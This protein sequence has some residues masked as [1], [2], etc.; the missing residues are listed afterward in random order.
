L[1]VAVDLNEFIEGFD[2]HHAKQKPL[3]F[4]FHT[5]Y[6]CSTLLARCLQEINNTLVLKEPAPL[7]S[8]SQMWFGELPESD[9]GKLKTVVGAL[10]ARRFASEHVIVKTTSHCSNIMRELLELHDDNRAVFLYASLEETLASFL[11]DPARRREARRY[12][13]YI[14]SHVPWRIPA[15]D[16]IGFIDAQIVALLWVVQMR[17]YCELAEKHF[18]DR[19]LALNCNEFLANPAYMLDRVASHFGLLVTRDFLDAIVASDVFRLYAKDQHIEFDRE[20]RQAHLHHIATVY[21]NEIEAAQT[22]AQSLPLWSAIPKTLPNE[23][24]LNSLC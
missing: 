1:D 23:V 6:C 17:L 9:L 4:I 16:R 19:M 8:L 14:G 7:R 22:W 3:R 2:H 24:K 13:G 18:G 20:M 15:E 10:L 11:K 21:A 12:L 5:A